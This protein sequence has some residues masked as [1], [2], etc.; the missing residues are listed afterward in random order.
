MTEPELECTINEA[1]KML[2]QIVREAEK[3]VDE[4]ILNDGIFGFGGSWNDEC[5]KKMSGILISSVKDSVNKNL[6]IYECE[7]KLKKIADDI[8]PVISIIE[9]AKKELQ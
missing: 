2:E 6:N 9:A 4:N 3:F 7:A 1:I 8:R 5:G